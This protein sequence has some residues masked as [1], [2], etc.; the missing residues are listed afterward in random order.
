[1]V[2]FNPMDYGPLA[3]LAGVWEGQGGDDVAPSD[4]RGTEI[5][6]YRERLILEPIGAVDNHEQ[7]LYALRYSTMAWRLGEVDPF[8]EEVGYWMWDAKQKQVLRCFIVPRGVS[9]IAGGTVEPHAESFML[10]ADLGSATYGICSNLFLNE[11]FRTV[12]YEL[13]VT[14]HDENSF[15]YFEDTHLLL[16]GKTEVFHHTDTHRLKR[17]ES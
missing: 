11:E 10:K 8:H 2:I 12:K 1:M 9:V 13:T 3:T 7:K 15:S 5:N 4:D 17:V 14:I 6:K 16:K